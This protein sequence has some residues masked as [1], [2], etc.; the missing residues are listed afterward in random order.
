MRGVDGCNYDEDGVD[1]GGKLQI[2][3]VFGSHHVDEVYLEEEPDPGDGRSRGV[4]SVRSRS[5]GCARAGGGSRGG[6]LASLDGAVHHEQVHASRNT[7]C[8]YVQQHGLHEFGPGHDGE[9]ENGNNCNQI[10]ESGKLVSNG[11][12]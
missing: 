12:S 6:V 2:W 10:A 9:S 3:R 7:R 1:D 4:V 5:R 11:G 8:D